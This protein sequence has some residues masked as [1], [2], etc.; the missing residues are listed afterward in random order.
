MEFKKIYLTAM[1][2]Q[3]PRMFNE[4]RRSGALDGHVAMKW[5]QAS[6]IYQSLITGAD[7]LPSGIPE[8][9][10]IMR[11]AEEQTLA[12]MLEFPDENVTEPQGNRQE[13]SPEM[14]DY[15]HDPDAALFQAM[16]KRK[17]LKEEFPNLSSR[18]IFHKMFPN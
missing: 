5:K 15:L 11:S 14:K 2:E 8:D 7:L 18:E 16:D 12:A 4:L 3:A 1:R 13:L 10:Q 6:S 17:K 9:L